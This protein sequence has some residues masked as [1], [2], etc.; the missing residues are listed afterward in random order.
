VEPAIGAKTKFK[1]LVATISRGTGALDVNK[2]MEVRGNLNEM[3][4]EYTSGETNKRYVLAAE[5]IGPAPAGAGDSKAEDKKGDAKQDDA[6]DEK[7]GP[8]GIHCIYVSDIDLLDSQ[9]LQLRNLPDAENNFRFDN[10]AFALNVID[11]V[12]GDERFLNIRSRKPR[13]STLRLIEDKVTQTRA[14]EM[15]SLKEFQEEFDRELNDAQENVRKATAELEKKAEELQ[16]KS[17]EGKLEPAEV[18]EFQELQRKI[19]VLKAVE[20][21]RLT[22][23]KERLQKKLEQAQQRIR[24]EGDQKIESTQNSIKVA[25]STLPLIFPLVIGLLVYGRRRVREREGVSKSRLRY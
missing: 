15:K 3:R 21:Q 18:A 4:K 12:A 10:V 13:Y 19:Q 23:L 6:K 17:E 25:A 16:K 9:F 5:I 20:E 1:E 14:E 7:K 11:Q 24:R 8:R 2:W 22:A